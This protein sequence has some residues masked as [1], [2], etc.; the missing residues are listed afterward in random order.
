[1][2]TENWRSRLLLG[3]LQVR[4]NQCAKAITTLEILRNARP[5][6]SELF[7][8]LARAYQCAGQSNLAQQATERFAELSRQERSAAENKTQAEHLVQ[9]A[10][11]KARQNQFAAALE[12]LQQAL[13]KDPRNSN[14]YAQLAKIYFSQGD[15]AHARAAVDQALQIH[16]NH[17]EYLYVLGRILEGQG[18]LRGA[19]AA[20]E[21]AV[22]VNPKEADAYYEMG[23]IYL[24]LDE[25][26]R[27]VQSLRKAVAISPEDSDYR[28]ALTEAIR[29]STPR[30]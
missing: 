9:Q 26:Q 12:L 17:P 15:A 14:A 21:R 18:D 1:M 28:R 11:E 13:E 4:L 23:M 22:L 24:K 19:L 20:F 25:G 29:T 30:P 16:P 27:A 10:N 2:E 8:T 7:F 6:D 3:K 5:E